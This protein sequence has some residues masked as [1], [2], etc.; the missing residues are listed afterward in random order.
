MSLI[1]AIKEK[2]RVV[3]G[4]DTQTTSGD[5]YIK[6]YSPNNL[7]I[8][9]VEKNNLVFAHCGNKRDSNIVKLIKDYEFD[10]ELTFEAVV[11]S[12]LPRI[13]KELDEYKYNVADEHGN[14]MFDSKFIVASKNNA[15]LIDSN[16]CVLEI[17]NY[18]A[19]GN[20]EDEALL[21]LDF[22]KEKKAEERIIEII[23]A[24]SNRH[25]Y[26]G[27]DVVIVDTKN[28]TNINT[29]KQ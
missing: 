21:L 6:C 20:G 29:F 22:T 8:W 19:V 7:K 9:N 10:G 16:G 18:I 5:V 2:D 27:S 23:R 4:A 14:L 24:V 12:I 3:I 25:L 26:V 15:F 17:E 11:H 28:P 13:K 1:I